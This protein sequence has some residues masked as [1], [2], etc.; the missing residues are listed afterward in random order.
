[1]SSDDNEI[2]EDTPIEEKVLLP[3]L[4]EDQMDD[5]HTATLHSLNT[6]FG[7]AQNTV[8]RLKIKLNEAYLESIDQQAEIDIL[9]GLSEG[10]KKHL[11]EQTIEKCK[12]Q[13]RLMCEKDTAGSLAEQNDN[14]RSKITSITN[15]FS[16]MKATDDF[17]HQKLERLE[18]RNRELIE[19]LSCARR[20][21]EQT[22]TEP[23][24][25]SKRTRTGR[26]ELD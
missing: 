11:E 16:S 24:R 20:K 2:I 22:Q 21:D 13:Q 1:M 18:M 6:V 12:L 8:S 26:A 25:R 10:L 9:R 15:D 4:Y 19:I 14:L 7:M 5:W 23:L 3:E 17:M